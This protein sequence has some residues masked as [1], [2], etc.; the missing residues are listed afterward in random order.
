MHP[1]LRDAALRQWGAFT[2]SDVAHA[3]LA[4]TDVQ[5]ALRRREWSR[6]R[7]GVYVERDVLEDAIRRGDAASHRLR[8][9]AVL[10]CL[11]GRPAVSHAS[12][13]RLA[14]LLAPRGAE[15]DHV[16]LTDEQQW[17]TG[18]GYAVMRAA[19][20]AHHVRVD[21]RF[22]TTGP[23]RTLVDCA[24]SWSLE[25][26]VIAMDAAL[27]SEEVTEAE[28]RTA[29]LEQTHWAGIGAAARAAGLADGRAESPLETLGRL[30][31]LGS[32]LPAPELQM[33][34]HGPR[35]FVGRV[36]A[37]WEDAAVAVEFDGLVKYTD[38]FDGRSAAQVLWEE[39]RREDE[40]R[41]LGVRVL[42]IVSA[43]LGEAWPVKVARL[44]SLLATRSPMTPRVRATPAQRRRRPTA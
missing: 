30:R 40:L 15:A 36:D 44:R 19:L 24:R 33:D 28:L 9:A 3:G 39:K 26:A 42:R 37:W 11:G 31:M 2:A 8:C 13:A 4:P 23:A 14:G 10:L 38:P 25:D 18:R 29:V 34:L 12:A 41:D 22:R 7:R 21:G 17:R 16:S 20:P 35:G 43:D 6:L 1:V 27:H 32:G 5:S